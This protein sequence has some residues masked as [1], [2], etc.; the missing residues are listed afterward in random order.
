MSKWTVMVN[1]VFKDKYA[2][3][4]FIRMLEGAFDEDEAEIHFSLIEN[5][6]L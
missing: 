6:E 4:K 1:A 3:K 2:G 5:S